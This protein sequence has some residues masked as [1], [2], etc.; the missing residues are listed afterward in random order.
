[1]FLFS[2]FYTSA[3]HTDHVVM[4]CRTAV[5]TFINILITVAGPSEWKRGIDLLT[6]LVIVPD[7]RSESDPECNLAVQKKNRQ[8]TRLV[9]DVGNAFGALTVTANSKFLRSLRSSD[10]QYAAL[11]LPARALT[12][13]AAR[14]H[15]VKSN[16][17][18]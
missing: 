2:C 18:S 4:V 12:E 5:L 7:L 13:S 6:R 14:I 15:S 10:L 11:L 17:V 16:G 3:T 9:M 1:N 8:K